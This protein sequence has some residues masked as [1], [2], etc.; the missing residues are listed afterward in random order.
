MNRPTKVTKT[1]SGSTETQYYINGLVKSVKDANLHQT[2]Y[3][4]DGLGRILTQTAADGGITT[5][6]YDPLTHDTVTVM[7]D[8]VGRQ[9]NYTYD[10]IDRVTKSTA[11]F[12]PT[13]EYTYDPDRPKTTTTTFDET[14]VK[15]ITVAESDRFGRLIK[16]TSPIG[17]VT[18]Q[19]IQRR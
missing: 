2:S 16:S 12:S 18:D 14:G 6:T 5:S 3:D 19:S 7:T 13:I 4:Y 8:A 17:V 11:S 10:N 15:R 9:T 1:L